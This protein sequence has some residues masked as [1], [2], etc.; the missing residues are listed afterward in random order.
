VLV[1]G[2][3]FGLIHL[4]MIDH[5]GLEGWILTAMVATMGVMNAV[6]VIRTGSLWPSIAA[7]MAYNAVVVMGWFIEPPTI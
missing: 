1:N 5:P 6:W 2:V 7:H 3:V 4:Y